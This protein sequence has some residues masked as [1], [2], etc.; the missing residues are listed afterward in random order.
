MAP[1]PFRCRVR[2]PEQILNIARHGG[3][4]RQLGFVHPRELAGQDAAA[5]YQRMCRLSGQRQ[6]PCVLDTFMAAV[7]FMEGGPAKAW[8]EYTGERKRLLLDL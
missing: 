8:W 3:D 7:E 6:D 2:R 5:L 4:F 1:R